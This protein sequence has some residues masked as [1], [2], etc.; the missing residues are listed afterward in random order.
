MRNDRRG[1]LYELPILAAIVVAALAVGFGQRG[2]GRGILAALLTALMFIGAL[3]ALVAIGILIGWVSRLGWVRRILQSKPFRFCAAW[4]PA[5][6]L[7]L[8]LGAAGS[9]FGLVFA[10]ASNA[11]PSAQVRAGICSGLALAALPILHRLIRRP[12]DKSGG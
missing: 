8:F 7:A 2:L 4:A 11:S 6:L 9:F 10:E 3:A 12:T 5:L 1:T